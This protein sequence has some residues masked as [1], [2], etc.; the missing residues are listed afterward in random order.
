MKISVDFALRFNSSSNDYHS[1]KL[2][3]WSFSPLKV[4]LTHDINFGF[5]L[6]TCLTPF[7]P[8]YP[9]QIVN[10]KFEEFILCTSRKVQQ[11]LLKLSTVY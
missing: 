7:H 3:N 2:L 8:T 1:D 6:Y 5:E 10:V 9:A 4:D 11:T